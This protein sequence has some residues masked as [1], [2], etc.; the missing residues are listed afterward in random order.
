MTYGTGVECTKLSSYSF[1]NSHVSSSTKFLFDTCPY[2]NL[3]RCKT[4][5]V[6]R[7]H[8][9]TCCPVQNFLWNVFKYRSVPLHNISSETCRTVENFLWHMSSRRKFPLAPVKLYKI[10]F[11]T[12]QTVQTFLWHVWNFTKITVTRL[13][14]YE[15]LCDKCPNENVWYCINFYVTHVT[16]YKLFCD[17]CHTANYLPWHVSQCTIYFDLCQNIHVSHCTNVVWTRVQNDS[18]LILQF[19]LKRVKIDDILY[20]IFS[21]VSILPNVPI[22]EMFS[23]TCPVCYLLHCTTF[24]LDTCWIWH[25]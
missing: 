1:Q 11:D 20:K 22:F 8:V 6:R 17:T 21:H 14:L 18:C 12:C 5:L 10:S 4:L 2:W 15:H 13:T 25:V 24:C 3:P 19:F 23:D 16:L 9:D 7:F